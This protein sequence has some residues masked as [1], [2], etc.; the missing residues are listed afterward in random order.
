[1]RLEFH[2]NTKMP[3]EIVEIASFYFLPF[4][5]HRLTSA[6]VFPSQR[7]I[8]Y[9]ENSYIKIELASFIVLMM[10]Q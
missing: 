6:S 9:V 3:P 1:M 4:P 7:V 8:A 10:M 5:P 2:P